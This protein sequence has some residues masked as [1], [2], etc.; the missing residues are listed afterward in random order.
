M[1]LFSSQ[2]I[3]RAEEW[4]SQRRRRVILSLLLFGALFRAIYYAELS[5]GPAFSQHR[6]EASDMYFFDSWASGIVAGDWLT[7]RALH[8]L[9]DWERGITQG[10][11]NKYPELKAS[12]EKEAGLTGQ[13]DLDQTLWNRWMGGK[14]FHQEPLYPYMVAATYSIFGRDVRWVFVWQMLLGLGSILLVYC[15]GCKYFGDL[16]GT[17]SGLLALLY[18]PMMYHELLLLRDST[19]IFFTLLLVAVCGEAIERKCARWWCYFGLVS[20]LCLLLKSTY[21][22]YI[23]AS[24]FILLL[25]YRGEPKLF[26]RCVAPAVAALLLITSPFVMRNISL[27][28]P[29]F[30]FSGPGGA[31]L[32]IIVWN[33]DDYDEWPDC[34][35]HLKYASEY[36]AETNGRP[37][38]AAIKTLQTHKTVWSVARMVLLKI[39][40]VWHWFEMPN[41]DNIY[42]YRIHAAIL[43]WLPMTFLT[44]MPFALAGFVIALPDIKKSWPLYLILWGLFKLAERAALTN[45]EYPAYQQPATPYAYAPMGTAIVPAHDGSE[46]QSETPGNAPGDGRQ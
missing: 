3:R 29:P 43:S 11:L 8:P 41:N 5:Q 15:I 6:W 38:P 33:S 2:S 45:E 46:I 31:A 36:M 42:Y 24:F 14:A 19:M 16:T 18:A 37:L 20:G 17:L 23:L 1:N 39:K 28:V 35:T 9:V 7:N 22:P 34:A 27:G 13:K 10:A 25:T 4:L 40:G 30:A 26:L 12:V 32:T 44:C 21:M